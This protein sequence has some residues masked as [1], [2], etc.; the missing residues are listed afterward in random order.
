M[1]SGVR[2]TPPILGRESGKLRTV[3]TSQADKR[4]PATSGAVK[5]DGKCGK[6]QDW[7]YAPIE[8][9]FQGSTIT[10]SFLR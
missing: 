8:S 7:A 3:E 10:A 9:T 4:D 1:V 5:K 2:T 6:A